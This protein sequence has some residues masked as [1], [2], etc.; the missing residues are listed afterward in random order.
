MVRASHRWIL[1]VAY[2]VALGGLCL[3]PTIV[4]EP[5]LPQVS[6]LDLAAHFVL[7]GLHAALFIGALGAA[8]CRA[9]GLLIPL[10][11]VALTTVYGF[12]IE[13]LQGAIRSAGR[14]FDWWDLAADAVGAALFG[15]LIAILFCRHKSPVP[16][17]TPQE[18]TTP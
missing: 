3:A 17:T 14:H 15:G 7:F 10:G 8:A 6:G 12:A 4:I 11:A 9:R 1:F 16:N 5:L 13:C 2:T 18:T